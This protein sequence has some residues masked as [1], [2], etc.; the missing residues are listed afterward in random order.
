MPLN[1]TKIGVY[2]AQLRKSRGLT[3]NDVADK[4]Q[5]TYQAVSKWERGETLPDVSLLPDLARILKTTVDDLFNPADKEQKKILEEVQM[6][7]SFTSYASAAFGCLKAAGFWQ[8]DM[9]RF[10]G[11][12]GIAFRFVIHYQSCPSSPTIYNWHT[13][14]AAMMDRIGIH[15]DCFLANM[16]TQPITLDKIREDAS[17]RIKKSIDKGIAAAVWAPT[18]IPEFGIIHGYDDVNKLYF[19][20]DCTGRQDAALPYTEL[21][22]SEVP[23]LFYQIFKD[24]LAVD[25][26]KAS[27]NVL[28]YALSE[29]NNAYYPVSGY[30]SGRKAYLNLIGAIENNDLYVFGLSYILAT[31]G[32]SKHCAAEYLKNLAGKTGFT[33]LDKAGALYELVAVNYGK[34]TSLMPYGTNEETF[35]KIRAELLT[36]MKDCMSLEE[37]AMQLIGKYFE[38]AATQL[39]PSN[40]G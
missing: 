10:M 39:A 27:M 12:T 36:A 28:R 11:M 33:G 1:N 20:R 34:A 38:E 26:E 5:I 16:L 6:G 8:E 4:L 30:A 21:G 25:E 15:S 17:A 22:K 32:Y 23:E 13:E 35:E 24:K 3:Q 7:L 19:V 9:V 40:P 14:H 29:W 18:S 37:E 2:I 31:Y